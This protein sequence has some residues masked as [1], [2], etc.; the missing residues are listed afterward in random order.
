M[1]HD[2]YPQPAQYEP[3]VPKASGLA[4][5]ALVLGIVGF[6]I[7]PCAFLGMGFGIVARRKAQLGQIPWRRVHAGLWVSVAATF[8]TILWWLYAFGR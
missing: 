3:M 6:F 7:G 1:S 4:T 8:L 2:P 5:A